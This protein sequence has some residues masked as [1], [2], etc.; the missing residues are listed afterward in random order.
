MSMNTFKQKTINIWYALQR[1]MISIR[2]AYKLRKM[3]TELPVSIMSSENTIAYIK[4]NNCS[5]ARYGD[6]EFGLMFKTG[7]AGYQEISDGLAD[8]LKEVFRNRS[9]SL[10][11]CIPYPMKSTKEFVKHGKQFWNTWA[12]C[13]YKKVVTEIYRLAGEG[14]LFGDSFVSRP[15]TGYKVKAKADNLFSHLKLLWEDRD[16]LFVEG[17]GTRLGVGNDLFDNAK[18]IKRI[19]A[20]AENAFGVY[21]EVLEAV[22]AVWNGELVIMA[23][24]PTA[25]VLASDLSKQGI[26]ALDLGHI[27]IQYEWYLSG[28]AYKPIANKYVNEVKGGGVFETCEDQVYQSQIVATVSQK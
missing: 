12:L 13:N 6:G 2:N 16:V 11:I 5:I 14:Y 22:R 25:T 7:A 3:R 19:L 4:E 1:P 26:Q 23:L 28:E 8:A 24:G 15:F 17:E 18:S 27:D 9:T 21:Y 10:L 20:P